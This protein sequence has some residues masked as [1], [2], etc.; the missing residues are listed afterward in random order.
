MEDERIVSGYC[1]QIDQCRMVLC[2]YAQKNGKWRLCA[3]D[4]RFPEC[5]FSDSC[6]LA[7]EF[8]KWPGQE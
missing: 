3:T 1:R 4:C 7:Q 5:V 2:E 8:L 6:P